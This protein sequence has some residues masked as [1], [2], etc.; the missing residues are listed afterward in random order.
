[1]PVGLVK[2]DVEGAE[3]GVL[4]GLENVLRS[5]RPIVMIEQLPDSIDAATGSSPSVSFLVGLGYDVWEAQPGRLF[6][7]RL[8]R[9]SSLLLGRA[10]YRLIKVTKL[11]KRQYP[12]L[13]FTPIGHAFPD[14]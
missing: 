6:K 1:M 11:A 7:G 3:E 10:A 14:T 12:A 5:N 4:R 9:L 8:G 13:I 2:V